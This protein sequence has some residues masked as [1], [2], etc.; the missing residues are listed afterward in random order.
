MP[1]G[2]PTRLDR[3]QGLLEIGHQI[4]PV[5]DADGDAHQS[6]GDAGL[7]ELLSR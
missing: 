4:A 6:V 5:L 3:F 1:F 7:R 2:C